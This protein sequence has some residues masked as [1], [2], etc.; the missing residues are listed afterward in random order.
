MEFYYYLNIARKTKTQMYYFEWKP[1]FVIRVLS[2][3]IYIYS[4]RDK[5]VGLVKRVRILNLYPT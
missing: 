5:K 3:Y 2:K 1:N 4:K